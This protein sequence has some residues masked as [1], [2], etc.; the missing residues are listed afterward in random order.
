M[1]GYSYRD[2]RHVLKMMFIKAAKQDLRD[3]NVPE[4]D[5]AILR[6]SGVNRVELLKYK[7]QMSLAEPLS[8]IDDVSQV[9]ATWLIIGARKLPLRGSSP[10]FE[11][12]LNSLGFQDRFQEML[13]KM[14][15]QGV[16]ALDGQ[17]MVSLAKTFSEDGRFSG[18]ADHLGAV[19]SN[20]SAKS[21][22]RV[23]EQSLVADNL[24]SQG[25]AE[26]GMVAEEVWVAMRRDVLAKMKHW[27]GLQTT[28]D[29]HRMRV[30]VYVYPEKVRGHK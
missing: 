16:V 25:V 10:S 2:V 1:S 24:S 28:D 18:V 30:G 12:V 13:D 8:E 5:A 11:G 17:G 9:I 6:L 19:L 29:K 7:D 20:V 14:S 4:S 26:V 15:A 22:F 21:Q 27:D 3:R 23:L